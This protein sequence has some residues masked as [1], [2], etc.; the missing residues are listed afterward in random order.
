[1]EE[2]GVRL[3]RV[4]SRL[5][6]VVHS[7]VVVRIKQHSQALQLRKH[8]LWDYQTSYSSISANFLCLEL[9]SLNVVPDADREF[10]LYSPQQ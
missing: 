4:P 7:A 6:K 5:A 3:Q 8:V 10:Q 2:P 9:Q 1:M